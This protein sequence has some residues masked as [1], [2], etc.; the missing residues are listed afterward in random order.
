MGLPSDDVRRSAISVKNPL[1]EEE[2]LLRT[3]LLP[4]LLKSARYNLSHG[5]ADV[6]LYE[7]GRVFYDDES[8]ELGT[9]PDQPMQLAFVIT[10]ATG[11]DGVHQE[12]QPVDVF[13]ATAIG[14]LL[15]EQLQLGAYEF[16]SVSHPPLHPARAAEFRLNGTVI[17]HVGE[18]HPRVARAWDLPG[19]VGV[20]EI[21][22]EPLV[23]DR[24]LWQFSEPSV[25][26]HSDFDL[27]FEADAALAAS[28]IVTAAAR[29]AGE[30]LES[31]R[32]FD[33]FTGGNLPEGS[34][35]LAVRIRLRAGDRTLTNEEAAEARAAAIDA[36]TALGAT[37]RGA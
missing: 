20:G 2:S 6:A 33:E 18:L 9:V 26:P 30:L 23:S 31:I 11:G 14:R 3:T 28:E 22:V 34:K 7:I 29:G 17:G 27:A 13:H 36:V 12:A 1:S 35:S 32:L 16:N 37:L 5:T 8:P 25:Y 19:R 24:G 4:G 10:G 15:V 21:Q